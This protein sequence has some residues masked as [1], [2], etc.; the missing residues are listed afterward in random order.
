MTQPTDRADRTPLIAG[1]QVMN[2]REAMQRLG[3]D[4]ELLR[5]LAEMFFEDAEALLGV[6]RAGHAD[7]SQS[8][9]VRRAA[10]SLKGLSSNFGAQRTMAAAFAVEKL[11]E[12]SRLSELPPAVDELERE[13]ARLN[14]GLREAFPSR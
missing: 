2:L 4:E 12:A 6:V 14:A 3:G 1:D 11:A 7:P 10:H 8:Q 13:V 5:E 9:E